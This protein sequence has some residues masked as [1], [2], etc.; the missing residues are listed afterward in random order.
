MR[1]HPVM[2][3]ALDGYGSISCLPI[4]CQSIYIVTGSE[5]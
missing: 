4:K 3:A 2:V 1:V 5:S